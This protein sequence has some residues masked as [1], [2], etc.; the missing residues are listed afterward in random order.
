MSWG[1][2][3]CLNQCW[4]SPVLHTASPVA[5]ELTH[6]GLGAFGKK[7][8]YELLNQ[9]AL[10]ILHKNC[11]FLW[12]GKIFCVEF[13][14]Y[15]F[16]FHTKY[17]PAELHGMQLLTLVLDNCFWSWSYTCICMVAEHCVKAITWMVG[18]T[19]RLIQSF[20]FHFLVWKFSPFDIIAFW[21]KF[22]ISEHWFR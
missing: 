21:F 11:I 13:Q 20:Q 12:M 1:I 10:K 8:T 3:P 19:L 4:P 5:Y 6:W 9:R 15:P 2:K 17:L 14:R 18:N 7:K 22:T 16:K